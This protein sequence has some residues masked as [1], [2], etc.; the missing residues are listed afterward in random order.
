MDMKQMVARVTQKAKD[1]A[2]ASDAEYKEAW[3]K[4]DTPAAAAE[5]APKGSVAGMMQNLTERVV[6][7]AK[8]N[9]SSAAPA[10][11]ATPAPQ[12]ASSKAAM[13]AVNEPKSAVQ[14]QSQQL[15]ALTNPAPQRAAATSTPKPATPGSPSAT[16][17]RD[18][19]DAWASFR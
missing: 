9:S 14:T 17:E 10:P 4:P 15:A 12:H 11:D 19:A 8:A 6:E 18:F 1:R 3:D 2:A 13:A 5:P 7:K 16:S